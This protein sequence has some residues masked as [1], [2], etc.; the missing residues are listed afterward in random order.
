MVKIPNAEETVRSPVRE[1]G[2]CCGTTKAKKEK[3]AMKVCFSTCQE[4]GARGERRPFSSG[5][6]PVPVPLPPAAPDF[7]GTRVVT[8]LFRKS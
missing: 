1:L 5:L 2:S 6:Q 7:S 8:L 4:E 3:K